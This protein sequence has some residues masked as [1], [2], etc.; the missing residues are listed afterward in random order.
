M[1][2][3]EEG[4]SA[5]KQSK[6]RTQTH[7]PSNQHFS[8]GKQYQVERWKTIDNELITETQPSSQSS[9][10]ACAILKPSFE[11]AWNNLLNSNDLLLCKK[12]CN[13]IT[14]EYNLYTFM[15]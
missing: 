9:S 11:I 7:G 15:Q 12:A 2:P 13:E 8:E 6:V 3:A 10:S 14:F 5:K 4:N 1:E